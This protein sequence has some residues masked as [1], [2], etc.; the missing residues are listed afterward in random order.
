MRAMVSFS[1]AILCSQ[2]F[3]GFAQQTPTKPVTQPTLAT[4]PAA[5]PALQPSEAD[6]H[7][8]LD[9]VV[10]DKAGNPVPGLQ[11]PDFAILDDK[12]PQRIAS[13][14]AAEPTGDV[15]DPALQAVFIVDAVNMS[16]RG[17]Q[18]GAPQ[19]QKFLRQDG[20]RLLMPTS[21]VLFADPSSQVQPVPSRDGNALAAS[22]DSSQLGSR[23]MTRSQ[24]FY[25]AAER[26]QISLRTLEN[27]A[28]YEATQPGRKL[29]IWLSSGWPSF[30]GPEVELSAKE[31]VTLFRSLVALSTELREARITLYSIDPLGMTDAG[32]FPTLYYTSFL[33]GVSSPK[34]VQGG[35]L[36][37]QVLAVQSGGRVLNSGNDITNLVAS[38]LVDAKAF[39]SISF[40]PPPGDQPNE[41][42]SLQ[43]K[44]GKP[45]LT[46]RTRTGYYARPSMETTH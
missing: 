20:G 15:T 23:A 35:N 3:T 28:R 42:H 6:H 25:G 7:I 38:C 12:Q 5:V 4:R 10:T 41:Y 29:L 24:G 27:L 9:V 37:L 18:Y 43:V 8:L 34:N 40:D 2:S 31:Q 36:A 45:G 32:G 13:F 30:S 16:L 21:L 39:Y 46:A 14:H 11:E 44:I 19:L 22:L 33:R 1:V 26:V 17:L